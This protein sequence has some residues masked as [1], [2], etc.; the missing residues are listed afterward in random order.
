MRLAVDITHKDANSRFI[1]SITDISW[2]HK[3]DVI[4]NVKLCIVLS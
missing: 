3:V 1:R 4:P 2:H